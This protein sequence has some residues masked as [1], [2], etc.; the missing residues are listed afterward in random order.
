MHRQV[1][2]TGAVLVP[3]FTWFPQV[4]LS[5]TAITRSIRSP[6]TGL[7]HPLTA[8]IRKTKRHLIV[9]LRHHR[10]RIPTR[11]GTIKKRTHDDLLAAMY[12]F[13]Y[14]RFASEHASHAS[15]P[16]RLCC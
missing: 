13:K 15:S 9:R 12:S 8:L 2:R 5:I 11:Q 6:P 7:Q 14:A 10:A 4:T 3:K 16:I 1:L